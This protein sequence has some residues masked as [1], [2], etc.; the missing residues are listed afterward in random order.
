ML[1]NVVIPTF[2]RL[3]TLKK[4]LNSLKKCK[5]P[6]K[7]VWV[8]VDGRNFETLD[9]LRDDFPSVNILL[10][11]KR[12]D[13]VISYNKAFKLLDEG[14]VLI[15]TDD[16][17]FHKDCISLAARFLAFK[18]P[19]TDGLIG[20]NQLQDG[21]PKGRKYAFCLMGREFFER[22]E[23]RVV[24]CPDYIHFNGDRELGIYGK[25]ERR[26]HFLPSAKV[27][28]IRLDDETTALGKEVYK[29]D[30]ETW[31]KRQSRGLLWGRSFELIN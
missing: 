24:F 3:Q 6:T 2:K 16:L 20:L 31:N 22:Y 15:A 1:I 19:S 8:V 4:T 13:A 10:N 14:A 21:R 23:K 29:K 9:M 18:F 12:R 17:I 28:H 27:D 5:Y 30:R 11:V 7:I 25:S 26:F